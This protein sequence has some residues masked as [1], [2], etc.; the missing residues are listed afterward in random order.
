MKIY[1]VLS[2]LFADKEIEAQRSE[3]TASITDIQGDPNCLAGNRKPQGSVASLSPSW[4][5]SANSQEDPAGFQ[6]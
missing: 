6:E 2:P 1:E 4:A 3:V 5:V